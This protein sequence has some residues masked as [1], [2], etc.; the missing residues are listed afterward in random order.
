M[1]HVSKSALRNSTRLVFKGD[2]EDPA[3]LVTKALADFGTEFE[4][5]FNDRLKGIEGKEF[6]IDPKLV[7]RLDKIEAKS[8]R[9]AGGNDD[10]EEKKK[11]AAAETKAWL[12]YIRKGVQT[13]EV[14]LKVLTV[15]NDGAAGY[16]A[17]PEVSKEFIR[18][19][20]QISPIRQYA[21][22]RQSLAPSVK[23]P[24]RL[25]GTDAKWEN[26]IEEAEESTLTFGQTEIISNRL[27]TFV[28]L[29]NSLI[30][31][32]DGLAEAEIRAAFAEDFSIKE[33]RAFIAGTG[34]KQPEGILTA[35]AVPV[36]L[37]GHASV[38]QSDALIS[39][40]YA[41]PTQ[42][43]GRGVWIM[44]GSTVAIVRKLKDSQGNYL[45][46]PGLQ[47]NEPATLLGRPIVEAPDMPELAAGTYPIAFG[48]LGTGYRIIDR[49]QLGTLTDPYRKAEFAITRIYGTEWV[50]GGVV[51]P[52]AIR[53]LKIATS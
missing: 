12:N 35:P 18:D 5:K 23:Y 2:D 28:E 44:T 42:Y 47:A 8:N 33:G 43:R 16:L 25:T 51:Q 22:V 38:L 50:G 7:A 15:A 10:D 39:L 32:S 19:L 3:A 45:W 20:T 1:K 46:A 14:E 31:G 26:E 30:M 49:Q 21:T 52:N 11:A 29:S 6:V 37:N 36:V 53:K 4:K 24:K 34:I 9:P 40:M 41:L 17:P 13:P 48:D 27:T